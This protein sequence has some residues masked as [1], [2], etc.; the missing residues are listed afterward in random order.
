MGIL[1]TDIVSH[2]QL[3]SAGGSVE[4]DGSG[5][6]LTIPYGSRVFHFTEDYTIDFYIKFTT[7]SGTQ[8]VLVKDYLTLLIYL[9]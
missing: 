7:N 9:C 5:D 4:F 6:Y 3:E 1:R 2:S 8:R